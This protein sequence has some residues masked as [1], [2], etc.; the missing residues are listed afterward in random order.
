LATRCSSFSSRAFNYKTSE[1]FWFNR[2][3]IDLRHRTLTDP[4]TWLS[5]L[6]ANDTYGAINEVMTCVRQHVGSADPAAQARFNFETALQ[7]M[8]DELDYSR[9]GLLNDLTEA[10]SFYCQAKNRI[11]YDNG[12]TYVSVMNDAVLFAGAQ[13]N[14]R[15]ADGSP[16]LTTTEIGLQDGAM[17]LADRHL[18]SGWPD[19]PR[20]PR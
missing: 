2:T 3:T 16:Q 17:Y 15:Q 19:H 13:W 14:R 8:F 18:C 1:H 20:P 10:G 5:L 12:K 6:E 7:V 4:K 9:S 11:P